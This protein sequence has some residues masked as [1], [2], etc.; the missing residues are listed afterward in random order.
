MFWTL[1]SNADP[2]GPVTLCEE[3]ALEAT[4]M[5]CKLF[6]LGP[7]STMQEAA[8]ELE[9]I[10]A[11]FGNDSVHFGFSTSEEGSCPQCA[12]EALEA[13]AHSEDGAA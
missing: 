2:F 8:T 9:A 1:D 5:P 10:S 6:G 12:Y 3:H 11:I 13:E 4:N 7:Y